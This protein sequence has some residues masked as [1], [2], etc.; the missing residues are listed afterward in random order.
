MTEKKTS[1]IIEM[2]DL[3]SSAQSG[4]AEKYQSG[5][6]SH[7]IHIWWARRPFATM[8]PIVYAS[9]MDS[10]KENLILFNNLKEL[11]QEALAEVRN[12]NIMKGK[13]MLDMFGGSGTIPLA[14]LLLGADVTTIDINRLSVFI[15]QTLLKDLQAIPY[16]HFQLSKL[17]KESGTRVLNKLKQESDTFY[18]GREEKLIAY[19]HGYQQV[20]YSCKHEYSLSL[21][22]WLVNRKIRTAIKWENH[23]SIYSIIPITDYESKN[24]AKVY[25]KESPFKTKQ[26]PK[27]KTTIDTFNINTLDDVILIE[28]MAGKVKSYRKSRYQTPDLKLNEDRL[29]QELGICYEDIDQIPQWSGITNPSLYGMEKYYQVLNQRQ[30]VMVLLLI[31]SLKEE[32]HLLQNSDKQLAKTVVFLLSGLIDQLVDWN[33]RLTI[34]ISQNQQPGRAFSGPGIPM[35]WDYCEIDPLLDGPANLWK[36]LD[37]IIKGVKSIPIT[38]EKARVLLASA[39]ELPFPDES[40]D[41]IITDPPYYDNIYYSILADFFYIWKKPLFEDIEPDLFSER[42]TYDSRELVASKHRFE[43][44]HDTY[45]KEM[46]ISLLEAKRVLKPKGVLSFLYSHSSFYGWLAI[47]E[48]F[49]KT[50]F[51][52][53]NIQPL[54]IER[55]ARPRGMNAKSIDMCF[56]LVAGLNNRYRNTNVKINEDLFTI[57]ELAMSEFISSIGQIINNNKIT[58]QTEIIKEMN[59]IEEQVKTKYSTFAL[60]RR[61]SL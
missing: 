53:R 9:L 47:I 55:K 24:Y 32:Y 35:Y 49:K 1:R 48:A 22:P 14:G 36:K 10:T 56:I 12:R 58:S 54:M 45:V 27:C 50:G 60:S 2:V 25:K 5:K 26:C 61:Y 31:K 41:A 16:T 30:R 21:R 19:L 37:R 8:L 46:T 20:C 43:D 39:Q 51:Q 11:N 4:F 15:Q 3:Q 18:P 57:Q 28:V 52:V 42:T 34:W 23:R 17:L 13:S 33:S 59:N 44:S 6:T 38:G 29:L 40:F 7:T